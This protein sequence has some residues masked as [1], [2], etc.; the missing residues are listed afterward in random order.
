M[1]MKAFFIIIFLHVFVLCSFAGIPDDQNVEIIV[2]KSDKLIT[3][4]SKYLE[5]PQRWPEVAKIN[6][7]SNPHLILPGQKLII[8]VALLKGVPLNA[9]VS[10]VKGDVQYKPKDSGRWRELRLNDVVLQGASI[11]TGDASAAEITF[12]D[13]T[14]LILRSNT[15]L[16]VRTSA[17]KG[18]VYAVRDF[19]L[20]AGRTVSKLKEATGTEPRFKIYTPSSVAAARGTEF[21]VSVDA[22]DATRAEV[23]H[24][25]ISVAAKSEQVEVH[26]GEGTLVKKNEPPLRPRKLLMPP[27]L[28][29]SEAVY[30]TIP[31]VLGFDQVPGAF[32][33]RIMLA[34]DREI[35]DLIVDDIIKTDQSVKLVDIQDGLYFL[36]TRS[37]DTDGLEGVTSEPLS[38]RVRTNPRPPVI[39]SPGGAD[40]IEGR[41]LKIKWL[42]VDD[43]VRYHLQIAE[44]TDFQSVIEEQTGL[45]GTEYI[46]RALSFKTYYLRV[47]SIAGDGYE[48]IWSK[49]VEITLLPLLPNPL[50]WSK[51]KGGIVIAPLPS[52]P[53]LENPQITGKEV[54]FRW[55]SVGK[56]MTYHFQMANDSSFQHIIVN[57]I[58]DSADIALQK[59]DS[60]GIYYIRIKAINSGFEGKFSPAKSFEIR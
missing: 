4:C 6:R 43:A 18:F 59:P 5:S 1:K 26:E 45:T 3:I 35:R 20:R 29:R 46:A 44:D 49:V 2:T 53:E 31:P 10:F 34:R 52:V 13:S 8:P 30:S 47:S 33:Y 48:G 21:S 25:T 40:A 19:F 38:I 23:L 42:K 15:A 39:E 28:L 22:L 56:G 37:I 60:P 14:T 41:T 55:S 16:E 51:V 9:K 50:F 36:Q 32:S 54:Y 58:V 12:E 7:L 24:G 11:K 27:S 17:T 57:R